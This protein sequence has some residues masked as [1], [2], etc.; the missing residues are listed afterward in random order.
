MFLYLNNPMVGVFDMDV[1]TKAAEEILRINTEA[2]RNKAPLLVRRGNFLKEIPN[3]W[4]TCLTKHP[5]LGDLIDTRDEEIL[6]YL[7][8][9]CVKTLDDGV[10]FK[11]LFVSHQKYS[12]VSSLNH[13]I[14]D[15]PM[16]NL[17]F[18]HKNGN[19]DMKDFQGQS[20]SSEPGTAQ[21]IPVRR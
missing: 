17:S 5:L 14:P 15:I 18:T 19:L 4:L 13:P 6:A 20:I 12:Q 10:G 16:C 9:V 21:N 11:I 2:E 7:E 8:Q 3:F 1:G